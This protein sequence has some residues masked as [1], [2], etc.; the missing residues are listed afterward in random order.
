[1]QGGG[2]SAVQLHPSDGEGSSLVVSLHVVV[3]GLLDALLLLA[4]L[5]ELVPLLA[6]MVMNRMMNRIMCELPNERRKWTCRHRA[7]ECNCSQMKIYGSKF[8]RGGSQLQKKSNPRLGLGLVDGSVGSPSWTRRPVL[9]HI[10]A[11]TTTA[12]GC[13]RRYGGW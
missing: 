5:P 8:E 10:P 3:V 2:R 11:R 13:G 6:M 9:V 12:L 1:M 4:R 7:Q